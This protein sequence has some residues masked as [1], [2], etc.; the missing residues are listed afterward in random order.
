MQAR[1]VLIRHGLTDWNIQRRYLGLTDMGLNEEGVRQAAI[2]KER[3]AHEHIDRVY[4]SDRKRARDFA[5]LVFGDIKIT[6]LPELREI[7]FGAFE[8]LTYKEIMERYPDEYTAW[9]NDPLNASIPGG[10][11]VRDVRRRVMKAVE[12]IAKENAGRSAA[13]V[14]HA[15]PMAIVKRE[16]SGSKDFWAEWPEP[17][18]VTILELSGE[19]KRWVR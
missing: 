9:I 3:L 2:V 7:E 6:A 11:S 8:G 13:V 12:T 15:G 14:T 19:E 10:E 5:S 1:L 17:A 4:S 18:C 16:F